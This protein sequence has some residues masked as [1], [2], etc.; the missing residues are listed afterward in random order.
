MIWC[1]IKVMQVAY[2]SK[3]RYWMLFHVTFPGGLLCHLYVAVFC[4]KLCQNQWIMTFFGRRQLS[5]AATDISHPAFL[6]TCEITNFIISQIS[7]K[8]NRVF[9]HWRGLYLTKKATFLYDIE[10]MSMPTVHQ[11][12]N[13]Y[14][15]SYP[16]LIPR[17][18]SS[19]TPHPCQGV[20]RWVVVS[21]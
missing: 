5:Q 7:S 20:T 19:S 1:Q 8:R 16:K 9:V 11:A 6:L 4:V 15:A 2:Q 21:E 18:A 12:T 14:G 17:Y 3:S 13:L 10:T